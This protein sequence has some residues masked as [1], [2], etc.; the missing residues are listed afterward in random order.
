MFKHRK[1]ITIFIFFNDLSYKE[2]KDKLAICDLGRSEWE[3]QTR[4]STL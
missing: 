2:E 1:I 4:L 3:I